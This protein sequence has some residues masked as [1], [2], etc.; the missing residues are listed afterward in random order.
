MVKTCLFAAALV[1]VLAAPA[2]AHHKQTPPVV[3]FVTSG[4][5]PL[6]RLASQNEKAFTLAV[7]SGSGTQIVTILPYIA[8]TVQLL[9]GNPGNNANPAVAASG[10]MVVWDTTDDPLHLG[11][12][13][14]QLVMSQRGSLTL[15]ALTKDPTGTSSNPAVDVLGRNIAFESTGDLANTGN[16][17][18]RQIFDLQQQLGP[19]QQAGGTIVQLSSGAGTSRNPTISSL[20]ALIAFESTSDPTTGADTGISQIWLGSLPPGAKPTRITSGAGPSFNPAL[21]DDRG[22][23]AFESTADLAG[24]GADTGVSQI[25]IYDPKAND[26]A[27]IT[28][29]PGGCHLPGVSGVFKDFRVTFVCSGEAYFYMLAAD[30][31]FHVQLGGVTQRVLGEMGVHFIMVS[32]E[33]DPSGGTTPYHQVYLVNLFK[34]PAQPDLT[35]ATAVWFPARGIPPN[36]RGC[37]PG[38]C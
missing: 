7:P 22:V 6:P 29:D 25:F 17:G 12:P 18:A 19:F 13:G 30:L 31:R 15:T 21:S 4:D 24:T 26:F 32:S 34:R 37:A 33:G 9:G 8:P 23:L 10:K 38:V 28:N 20:G 16:A 11:L 14:H 35:H 5:T 2:G 36:P 27:R 1:A 3:P